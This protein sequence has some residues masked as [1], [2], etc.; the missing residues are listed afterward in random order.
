MK[1]DKQE[2]EAK[3]RMQFFINILQKTMKSCD[4][5]VGFDLKQKKLVIQ[6]VESQ[7]VCRIDLIELNNY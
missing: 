5:K 7:L 1:N 4:M 3:E 6:D 2:L